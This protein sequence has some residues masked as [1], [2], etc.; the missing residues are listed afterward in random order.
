[1]VATNIAKQR[2]R[3]Y[4]DG[5][6]GVVEAASGSNVHSFVER[7]YPYRGASQ[8]VCRSGPSSI[9]LL[10]FLLERRG[11]SSFHLSYCWRARR[12]VFFSFL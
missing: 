2:K 5:K 8:H 3:D 10:T 12:I 11:A 6:L 9:R 4:L 7:T 1:M